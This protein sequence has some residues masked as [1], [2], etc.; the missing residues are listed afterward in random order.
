MGAY[1]AV[2]RVVRLTFDGDDACGETDD[3]QVNATDDGLV[4]TWVD[5]GPSFCNHAADR[6]FF[7]PTWTRAG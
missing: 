1:E 2:G 7:E 5:C 6:A 4:I 3:I